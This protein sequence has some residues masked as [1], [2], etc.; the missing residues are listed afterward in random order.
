MKLEE[1][2]AKRAEVFK[3]MKALNKK[4]MSEDELKN[5]SSLQEEFDKVVRDID[6]L[7]A[8][9]ALKN[10][11]DERI[12]LQEVKTITAKTDYINAFN[13]Y[14]IGKNIADAKNVMTEGVDAD[15]GYLVPIEYQRTVIKKLNDM[16]ATRSVSS[17]V[18][19]SSTRNIPTEGSAPVFAWVDETGA[20]GETSSTFG[21]T[22]L[23]A[24]KLGGIIKVAEELLQDSMINFEAY[25]AGQI[26]KGIDK[27]ESP[28]FAVGDG[29]KKPT[30]YVTSAP[31]GANS[32]TAATAA[33]TADEL[34]DIFYDLKAE[35]RKNAVW[36]MTDK[37]EKAIR[38]LK[39]ANGNYIYDARLDTAGRATLLGKPIVIDN[40]M[41]E[42][43]TGNKFIV[44][45]DFSYYN[46]A[47]R[48]GMSIQ[49]L[50]ELYAGS[51]MVGFKVHK[52]LDAK[53]TI[54]E[55]FNAGQNS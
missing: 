19:T 27:A 37:T 43:G 13:N 3:K 40:S 10:E 46:I 30:G 48:G 53:I 21:M 20:Y 23:G 29:V 42:L 52:R 45:G 5:F 22:Q 33:V 17:V 12:T 36:R 34:V 38:K 24:Y 31:V 50:N 54:A 9:D 39:D 51:G 55:A 11:V 28:A 4:E 15:G 6:L 2:K 1:A 8:E 32:T 41:S 26:A 7:Q 16:G 35:Y 18:G 47:D 25:M 44:I 49:R 14:I